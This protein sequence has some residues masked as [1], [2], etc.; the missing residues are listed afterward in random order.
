MK[1][2]EWSWRK[3][4]I[5]STELNVGYLQALSKFIGRRGRVSSFVTGTNAFRRRSKTRI[6]KMLLC[7]AWVGGY[8]SWRI[9]QS[10]ARGSWVASSSTKRKS[11]RRFGIE[12]RRTQ[13]QGLSKCNI[14][15]T[16]RCFKR[17]NRRLKRGWRGWRWKMRRMGVLRIKSVESWIT[18]KFIKVE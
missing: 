17:V 5:I 4:T 2:E 11:A 14:K 12:A 7:Q 15:R 10:D 8:W 16:D 9:A 1:Y 6:R 3:K 13:V 18:A